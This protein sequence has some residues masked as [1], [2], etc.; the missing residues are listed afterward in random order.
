MRPRQGEMRE[1][2]LSSNAEYCRR[3]VMKWENSRNQL[4]PAQNIPEACIAMYSE[5]RE[6]TPAHMRSKAHTAAS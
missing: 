6:A 2:D 5:P 1:G 4:K 3:L